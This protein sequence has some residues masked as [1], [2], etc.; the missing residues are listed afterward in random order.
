M[1]GG[2]LLLDLAAIYRVGRQQRQHLLTVVAATGVQLLHFLAGC[3]D[4][5]TGA[6]LLFL[7]GADLREHALHHLFHP[8]AHRFR[9]VV[10]LAVLD[11]V[12]AAVG[13]RVRLCR[14]IH[15]NQSGQRTGGGKTGKPAAADR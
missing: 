1:A 13:A 6:R 4:D 12:G 10:A 9:A 14:N 2:A 15:G 3:L 8:L 5:V 7:A 11:R